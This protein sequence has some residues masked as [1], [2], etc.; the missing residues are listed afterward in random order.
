MKFIKRDK[1]YA[2]SECGKYRICACKV[3]DKTVYTA[4]RTG[5]AASLVAGVTLK[6]AKAACNKDKKDSERRA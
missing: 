1:Y 2:D 3:M 5:K 4:W 6:E